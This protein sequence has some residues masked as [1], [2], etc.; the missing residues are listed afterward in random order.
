M[1]TGSW[2]D[3]LELIRDAARQA[4]EIAH[5]FFGNAP[6]VWWKN[7]GRS[8]VSAADFAANDRLQNLL[9]KARP[10]YGWL[11]EETDDDAARLSVET[12]FVIDPIDGTRAFINGQKTWCVSVAVVHRGRPVAGVLV[13]PALEE[14]FCAAEGGPAL[15]NGRPIA[16][17][18]GRRDD[19]LVIAADESLVK[20]FDPAFRE[21]IHRVHH[22]PSLAYR[23]AMVADGRIDG[24]IVKRNS[25]DW[26]LAAADLILERAGGILQDLDGNRLSYNRAEVSHEMLLAGAGHAVV[27]L[28]PH[29][30]G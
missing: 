21:E 11:S 4:A 1:A 23:L 8:P 13:A 7:E 19:K 20:K 28:A 22:V 29:L 15:K 3:D 6:E 27:S 10:N 12:L 16:V 14:E 24:T 5:G 30:P 26:D 9:L 17:T 2:Q 18:A 25:H